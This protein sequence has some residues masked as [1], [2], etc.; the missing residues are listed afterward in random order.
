MKSHGGSYH[1]QQSLEV[2]AKETRTRLYRMA[3]SNDKANPKDD[4]DGLYVH[5]YI[6]NASMTDLCVWRKSLPIATISLWCQ[7]CC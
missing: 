4:W 3:G 1:Q 7:L 2:V 5:I 6:Q